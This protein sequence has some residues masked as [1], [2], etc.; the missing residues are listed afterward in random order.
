MR[1]LIVD[2]IKESLYILEALLKATG[3]EVVSAGN[4]E[5][6]LEKLRTESIDII[7]SDVLMPVMD[8]FKLCKEV[9]GQDELKNIP[10]IF[11]T[12]TYKDERDEKLALK[13]GADKYILKPAEPDELIKIIQGVIRDIEEGKFEPKKPAL[14]EEKE[15]LKLYS[16]RLVNKLEKKMLNLEESEKRIKYLYSVL[17]AIRGVNQLIVR[18]KNRDILI[19]KTCDILIGVRGY[20]TAWLGFLKDEKTFAMVAGSPLKKVSR[21][22]EQVLRG[23]H[24]P[25][26][27]KAFTKKDLF[28]FMDRSRD[29]GDCSLK[30]LH[31]GRNSL[32]M[33]ITHKSKLFG[34]LVLSLETDVYIDGEEKELLEEVTGDIAFGLHNIELEEN[35]GKKTH[36]LGERVKELNCLYGISK[37]AEKQD[38]STKEIL[39]GIVDLIPP[40]WQYPEITCARIVIGDQEYKTNNFKKTKWMQSSDILVSND[41]VGQVE[42]YYLEE[43]PKIHEGPFL[44]EEKNL[45]RAITERLG[46]IIERKE[47]EKA[48]NQIEWLLGKKA[49]SRLSKK[50]QMKS[51]IPF[52]GDLAN[53]NSSRL[54]LDSIGSELLEEISADYLDILETSG[55]IYEKNGDYAL[56]IF[57]SGWCQYLDTASRKLCGTNDNRRALESGHW[58]CHESC[59]T[60]ASKV[61]I[62]KREPVDIE[63]SGGIHLYAVPIY[64]GGETVGSMNFGYGDPPKD[65][66]KLREIAEKYNVSTAELREKKKLYETRPDFLIDVAKNRLLTSAKLIGEIIER[67]QSEEALRKSEKKFKHLSL[68]KKAIIESPEGIIV[69]ALD[70]NYCYLD[71]TLLHKQTMKAIWGLDIEIGTNMLDYIKVKPDREKAQKNFDRALKGEQFVLYE[72]YGDEKLKRTFYED[73]YGPVFDEDNNIIGL[74]VYVIDITER[75]QAEEKIKEY[76]ENLE[77]M[78]EERTKKLDQS[79]KDMEEAR[80][81]I[82]GIVKSV[83]DG[84]I[85]TDTHNNVLLMNQAAENL[86]GVTLTNAIGTSLNLVIEDKSLKDNVAFTLD[87]RTTGYQYDFVIPSETSEQ[88]QIMRASSSVLLD[89]EGNRTGM[90]MIIHDV[91][92][93]RDV[94]RMKTEFLSTAAHELRMPLTSIQGFSELLLT[95]DNLE[96][97][98]KTKFLSYINTQAVGLAEIISDLLDISRIESGRGYSFKKEKSSIDESIQKVIPYFE[99]QSPNHKFK[100]DLVPPIEE[101]P[102]DKEKIEQVLKNLLSNAVKYSPDGGVIRVSREVISNDL[103]LSIEDHGLGM[104][105]DQVSKIFDKFYRADTSDTTVTGT[106]LGMSIVKYIIDAHGGKV[107]VESELGKG[108]TVKF[109]IPLRADN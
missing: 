2:D 17:G 96:E 50:R 106:G 55:A 44:K 4:G 30:K 18:E 24:P 69:F 29:C 62:E 8:G 52:Y 47:A 12:A 45:I 68:L 43:K 15:V 95:R 89:K 36:D 98:E 70:K 38:I 21:F 77:R 84:L 5:E 108:T 80:D 7:V 48:F 22:C 51:Y 20:N 39:Q 109:T 6:A 78:V 105:A 101:L 32:L 49:G 99:E 87:K 100:V 92:H 63:C 91:S 76:S 82:D 83:A 10:F 14:E 85:V 34:F 1:I 73:R 90:V 86:L 79:L 56:G 28:V 88:S 19:Q 103:L 104:N 65:P 16:E 71:F 27:K 33:R 74:A 42:I 54:I 66:E 25:C 107:W 37:L 93:E 13:L 61:S 67:K 58:H 53:L 9:K 40:S 57:S 35:L 60:D 72:E 102:V 94:D 11:Y 26:I 64:A 3:Y 75:K 23:D 41:K 31:L 81:Q 97:K 59:W 46:R